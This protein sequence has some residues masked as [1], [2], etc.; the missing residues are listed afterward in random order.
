MSPILTDFHHLLGHAHA[1]I[2]VEHPLSEMIHDKSTFTEYMFA[3]P[4]NTEFKKGADVQTFSHHPY[5]K[6]LKGYS[7]IFAR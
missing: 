5:N 3:K 6:I 7:G 4:K 1:S 2:F